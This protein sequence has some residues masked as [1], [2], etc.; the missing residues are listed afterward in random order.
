MT[1]SSPIY[2]VRALP[3]RVGRRLPEPVKARLRR[4]LGRPAPPRRGHRMRLRPVSE[5]RI[6][7]KGLT[8]GTPAPTFTLPD[9]DGRER[10]LAEFAGK[11]LLLVFMDPTC[12]PCEKLAPRLAAMDRESRGLEVLVVSRGEPEPNRTKAE[13][14]GFRFPVLLQKG[15]RVSRDYGMFAT[16]VAYLIG[17]DGVIESDVAAGLPDILE[18]LGRA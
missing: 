18:L 4:A 3:H 15:W 14:H 2:S 6:N 8:A 10:S 13:Q 7:R 1:A 12:K 16:P 5:S 11:R 9:I 17:A